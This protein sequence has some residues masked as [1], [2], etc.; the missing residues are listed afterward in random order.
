MGKEI[1]SKVNSGSAAFDL[2]ANRVPPS[3][4]WD[5]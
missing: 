2:P 1:A 3:G 4:D 5:Y